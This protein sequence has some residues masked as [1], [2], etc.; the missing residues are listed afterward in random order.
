MAEQ[1][2]KKGS[3]VKQA[4][5]LASAGLLTRFLGFVYRVPLTNLIGDA[6][7][8]IYAGAYYIY[9]FL[10]ILSSAGLPA[11]I[12][13]L[14]SERIALKQYRN[15]HRVFQ[16]SLL[17]SSSMGLL[18]AV[19]MFLVAEN[20]AAIID[21]P[22][23]YYS[24]LVLCPTLFIVAVMSVFRGYFQ[25]MN[26]MVPTAVSQII[27]QIFNAFFSVYLAYVFIS[28]AVP[29]G[30]KNIPLAAAGGVMGTGVGAVAGLLVV[31]FSYSLIRPDIMRRTRRCWQEYEEGRRELAGRVIKTA[32]PI[33]A[34]TA[35]FSITNLIDMFM[36][37]KILT[38]NG[39]S[40]EQAN[41]LYGQLS[42][43]YVTLSTLPVAI[44]TAIATAA[45]PSIAASVKRRERGQIHRKMNLTMRTSMIIS[46]PA[47]IG[48]TVL[49][50]E[51]I[52]MLFPDASDGGALLTVG[53]ISVIFLALC[54]TT[55]GILQGINHIK[56]PVMGALLGAITKTVMNYFL[57]AIPELNILGAV[58]STTG[59]YLVAAVFDV[60]ML[61]RITGVRFDFMGCFLKPV[62]GSAVMGAAAVGVYRVIFMLYP[63]NTLATLLAILFAMA[64]YGTVMLL[65]K[66]I[67][68]ED[69]Q[70]MPGGG[71]MV[72]VLRRYGML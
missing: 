58:L 53:G 56:V 26:T 43:K 61:S 32:W 1:T 67:C 49:G 30:E 68:E 59:C 2:R 51:I 33:I 12:S 41:V 46:V 62:I 38:G 28:M 16:V 57:I 14:V 27:E 37:M 9:T 4:A 54:Q 70:N 66:G 19:L 13:K 25:G 48:I 15:A 65:I 36:V 44:S 10:L 17:I 8:G 69:L 35:V 11:A 72:R 23:S 47:A 22:N 34:G 18:F 24:I 21:M 52:H 40:E 50:P 3:F 7:N 63:N 6:G 64:V 45:L 60:C 5:I 29:E 55:T 39:F 20:L 31:L 71:K 42:G